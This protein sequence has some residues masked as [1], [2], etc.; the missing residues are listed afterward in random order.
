[1]VEHMSVCVLVGYNLF[2]R[3]DCVD[4]PPIFH[5][6]SARTSVQTS[7]VSTSWSPRTSQSASQPVAAASHWSLEEEWTSI[8]SMWVRRDR[9]WRRRPARYPK[10]F[11]MI[12]CVFYAPLALRR[13]VK[14]YSFLYTSLHV[15]PWKAPQMATHYAFTMLY[16]AGASSTRSAR[17]GLQLGRTEQSQRVNGENIAEHTFYL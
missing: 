13:R 1:M 10:H 6:H 4:F 3:F 17:T 11:V 12:L 16:S 15:L 8:H 9:R 7:S 14:I 2:P 5:I